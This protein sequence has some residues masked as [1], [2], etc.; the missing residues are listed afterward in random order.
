[1]GPQ[2]GVEVEL[3]EVAEMAGQV[4]VEAQA[5]VTM[6]HVTYQSQ[7]QVLWEV[8]EEI[9]CRRYLASP[10]PLENALWVASR[11]P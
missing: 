4:L 10:Y 8:R 6:L 11:F 2:Q 1:V 7:Y 3:V 9:A 5:V